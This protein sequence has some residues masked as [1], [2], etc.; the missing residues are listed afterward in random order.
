MQSP[1]VL[2]QL[3]PKHEQTSTISRVKQGS[4]FLHQLLKTTDSNE[5]TSLSLEPG[6]ASTFSKTRKWW[7]IRQGF[8]L[9]DCHQASH[10]AAAQQVFYP[11]HTQHVQGVKQSVRPSAFVSTKTARSG[12]PTYKWV[13]MATKLSKT[14]KNWLGLAKNR[15]TLATTAK[16]AC[17]CRPHL[18]TT[19]SHA[20]CS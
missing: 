11:A 19:P 18:L 2:T 7:I 6:I 15:M 20:M 14:A 17:F 10:I 13:V 16:I 12:A 9:E 3:N 5:P 4:S 1:Y 8:V